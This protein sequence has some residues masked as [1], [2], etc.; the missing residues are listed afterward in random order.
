MAT[1]E[2]IPPPE[3]EKQVV[4]RLSMAEAKKLKDLCYDGKARGPI[5]SDGSF[6]FD[7]LQEMGV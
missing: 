3:P 2:L 5:G 1:V 6:L 4:I 7:L